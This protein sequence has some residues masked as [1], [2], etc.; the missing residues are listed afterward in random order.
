MSRKSSC[1]RT[2]WPTPNFMWSSDLQYPGHIIVSCF[3]N[4]RRASAQ[5]PEI[6]ARAADA[7]RWPPQPVNDAE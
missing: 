1:R 3:R 5:V 7:P 6:S 4:L 2:G